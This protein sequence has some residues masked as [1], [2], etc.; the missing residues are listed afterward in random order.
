MSDSKGSINPSDTFVWGWDNLTPIFWD[1]EDTISSRIAEPGPEG[2]IDPTD[3][4]P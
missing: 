1:E 2:S 4:L 3:E